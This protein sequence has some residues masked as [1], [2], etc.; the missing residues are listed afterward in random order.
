[1]KKLQVLE[2]TKTELAAKHSEIYKQLLEKG[3]LITSLNKDKARCEELLKEYQAAKQ[4]RNEVIAKKEKLEAELY[5]L[6]REIEKEKKEGPQQVAQLNKEI[7]ELNNRLYSSSGNINII[8]MD[9]MEQARDAYRKIQEDQQVMR[10]KEIEFEELKYL[11]ANKDTEKERLD[12][13][14]M[15]N[16]NFELADL[17][18]KKEKSLREKQEMHILRMEKAKEEFEKKKSQLLRDKEAYR[19]KLKELDTVKNS[20]DLLRTEINVDFL[21]GVWGD[22]S[23]ADSGEN[24]G[25]GQSKDG[26]SWSKSQGVQGSQCLFQ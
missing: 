7:E 22:F 11:F 16:K 23:E 13:E 19:R 5:S 21:F 10:N 24:Q 17:R 26:L 1:M 2:E 20:N 18:D 25:R 8:L 4:Q 9:L 12:A 6:N 14:Y 15:N 3:N